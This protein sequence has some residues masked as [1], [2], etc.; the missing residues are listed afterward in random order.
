[1]PDRYYRLLV[2][3]GV[4]GVWV[5]VLQNAGVI[6][7]LRPQS[8]KVDGAV[9]VSGEVDVG[10]TVQIEGTVNVDNIS[11]TVDVNFAQVV[12]RDLVESERG[13]FIGVSSNDD[14]VIPVHWGEVSVD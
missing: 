4:V 1:M 9:I 7:A 3:I 6:P 8:V 2:L 14:R 11:S 5:L 10:N 12:G 13:M